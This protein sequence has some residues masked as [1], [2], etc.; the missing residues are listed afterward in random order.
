MSAADT[1]IAI[2]TDPDA[3]IFRVADLGIIGNAMEIVPKLIDMCPDGC[4]GKGGEAR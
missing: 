1:V 4:G 3:P 2:N